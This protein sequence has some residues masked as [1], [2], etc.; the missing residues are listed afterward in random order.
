MRSLAHHGAFNLIY[1][2]MC[3][4]ILTVTQQATRLF[5]DSLNGGY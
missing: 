2:F 1:C 3:H 5:E 4:D